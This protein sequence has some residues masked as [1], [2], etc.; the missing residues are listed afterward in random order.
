MDIW[1]VFNPVI[2]LLLYGSVLVATGSLLFAFHFNKYQTI[3]NKAYCSSLSKNASLLGLII[4][5]LFFLS[6][7]GNMGGDL[8]SVFSPLMLGL[9]LDS[10][11]GLA[12]MLCSAGFL[13]LYLQGKIFPSSLKSGSTLLGVFLLLLS[14]V[15]SGHA[16][17][18]G[19]T[20]QI[21]LIFHLTGIAFWIGSLLPL[22]NMCLSSNIKNLHQVTHQFGKI[23]MF[24]VLG[25]LIAGISFAYMLIGDI[26]LL[27]ETSYGIVLCVK[28]LIVCTL[29]FLG[30]LNK[31][32]IV[33]L[34]KSDT[35]RGAIRLKNSVQAEIMLVLLVFLFT[36]LLTT[37]LNLPMGG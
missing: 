24:Y 2:K 13:V 23:A 14:F 7:S 12:A 26:S 30:A 6:I 28:V 34:I 35:E 16:S 9:A 25:L 18:L 8:G 32:W 3:E 19:T 5:A 1:I 15:I 36:S 10:K 21:L 33:P 4:S 27:I 11:S 22:R 20:A 37:S 17:K 31:F 29:L